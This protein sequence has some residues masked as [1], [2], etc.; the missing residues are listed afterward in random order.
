MKYVVY[1]ENSND[2]DSLIADSKAEA[3]KEVVA[4]LAEGWEVTKVCRIMKGEY[5]PIDAKQ[6][7][8]FCNTF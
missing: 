1:F 4:V 6:F 8:R 5:V 2:R 7:S 3:K